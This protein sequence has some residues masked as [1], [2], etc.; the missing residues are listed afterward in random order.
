MYLLYIKMP[1][2]EATIKMALMILMITNSVK[3]ELR[4]EV[5]ESMMSSLMDSN[6]L[7]RISMLLAK[8]KK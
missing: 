8:M 7:G 5:M 2:A 1:N 3:P 6:F 4:L